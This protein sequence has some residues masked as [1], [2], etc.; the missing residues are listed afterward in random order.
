MS[1][2]SFSGWFAA[3][4]LGMATPLVFAPRAS[5]QTNMMLAGGLTNT[6]ELVFVPSGEFLMGCPAKPPKP[7]KPIDYCTPE[8][9]VFVSSFLM[10]K[11][12]VTV[13]QFCEYLNKSDHTPSLRDSGKSFKYVQRLTNGV[14]VTAASDSEYP[15]VDVSFKEAE[16][17]CL[18]LS[19]VTGRKCRLPTEAE[20]EFAAKGGTKNR[21]YPWGEQVKE[22]EPNPYGEPTGAH[23]QLATPEGIFDMDGPVC[24]W[25]QDFYDESYYAVSP[26]K[27]PLCTR[28]RGRRVVR[29]GP[30]LRVLGPRLFQERLFLPPT[31]KRYQTDENDRNIGLR[32]VVQP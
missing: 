28:G 20:W 16:G 26:H 15:V 11:F 1:R 9:K 5:G 3:F 27:D 13:R 8:H 23:P 14:F 30:M 21:T 22:T 24:Q 6:L 18:W 12:P 31:W 2:S 25:C 19:G 17:Y 4:S 29:G 10:G 32:V 7:W